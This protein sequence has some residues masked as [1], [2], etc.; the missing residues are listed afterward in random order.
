MPV[1][2]GRSEESGRLAVGSR[3]A[4]R[5]RYRVLTV[6]IYEHEATWVDRVT[7]MLRQAGNPKANRS[8]VIR[9]AIL[10]LEEAVG[11]KDPNELL[12]DFIDHHV[13]RGAKIDTER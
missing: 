2:Q 11:E 6:S 5:P 12:Q 9:E 8:L 4:P 13:R 1:R 7:A 3:H 10:R